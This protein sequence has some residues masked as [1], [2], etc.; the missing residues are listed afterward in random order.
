MY[1]T[2][3]NSNFTLIVQDRYKYSA[4]NKWEV[5]TKCLEVES[6]NSTLV[7]NFLSTN[8]TPA[9]GHPYKYASKLNK[10]LLKTDLGEYKQNKDGCWILVDFSNALL[11]QKIIELNY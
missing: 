11:A 9:Y 3:T 1:D 7:L 2:Y 4:K 6:N 5:F 10:I 8:G